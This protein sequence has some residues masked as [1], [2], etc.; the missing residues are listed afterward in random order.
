MWWPVARARWDPLETMPV[1]PHARLTR[2]LLRIWA[3][4]LLVLLYLPIV[5]LVVLSFNQ[6]RTVGLPFTGFTLDWYARALGDPI[7]MG[8]LWNSVLVAIAVAVLATIIG[9]MAAFPL[10]RG[11]IRYP[12]AARVFATLPI[13]L[14]GMLLG[15]GILIFLRRVLDMELSLLT[16]ILGHLVFTTPFVILIVAARLQ[17]FDRALEWAAADLGATPRRT[18][19]HIILPLIWPAILAGALISVT[20]SID[21]FIITFFTVGPQVT[22]PIYI[23]TQIKFGVTPEVNAIA[24]LL[25]V[26]TVGLLVLGTV[27]VRVGRRVRGQGR[28]PAADLVAD[29][30]G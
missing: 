9:T 18:V 13:M 14:P 5:M 4:A 29:R 15:I 10:V 21:E 7:L 12:G 1:S 6:S 28:A 30:S 17:G 22:L 24:T 23:Y 27:G 25:L 20:L 11:G 19:R 16:V 2:R 26:A 3:V 8:A